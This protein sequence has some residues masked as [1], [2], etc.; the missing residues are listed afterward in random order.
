MRD[1]GAKIVRVPRFLGAFRVHREQKTTTWNDVGLLECEKLRRRVHGRTIS[2]DEAA[3]RAAPYLRRHV[4]YHLW[5]RLKM[6]IP[7][8]RTF[9]RTLPLEPWYRGPDE[10]DDLAV[11][12]PQGRNTKSV[13]G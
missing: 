9:V 7:G 6:L 8:Q 3:A 2:H 11:A 10:D 13:K 12:S 5:E 1:S 4:V